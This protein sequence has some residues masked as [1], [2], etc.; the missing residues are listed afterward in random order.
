MSVESEYPPLSPAP[1]EE[2]APPGEASAAELEPEEA[3]VRYK[4]WK[5]VVLFVL[6]VLSVYFVGADV[7]GF[8]SRTWEFAVP[9]LAILLAHE[10]GHYI[11]ARI[12]RVP[13]SLPYF[14]PLPVLTP[15]GTLGAIIFMPNRIRSRNALLDI[16]AAGPL[17]GM[18]VAIPVM[19]WGLALSH[20][21]ATGSGH[22]IQE[23]NC[24]L[25]AAL[26]YAVFGHIAAGQDVYLHPTALAAWIGFLVTFLNMLPFGQL[27]GGHV[28]YALFGD[29]QNRFARWMLFAPLVLVVVNFWVYVW[30]IVSRGLAH[31]FGTLHL[32]DY[33]PVSSVTNWIFLFILLL[34]MKRFSGSDHPPVDDR[35]MTTT[36]KVVAVATLG[37]FIAVFMPSPWVTF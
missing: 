13:S 7:W 1:G 24:L 19:V 33:A 30:P 18:A 12:H 36:R 29:R 16:G 26:K 11:A 4:W 27:D 2:T 32:D 28:A 21:G 9:L 17:A 14:L 6:T 37:L 23:G 35:H 25:Y 15:F 8:G 5:N 31:G 22:Y 3:P 20:L 10:F 34:V